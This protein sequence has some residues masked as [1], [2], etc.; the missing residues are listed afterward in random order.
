MSTAI[1]KQ[2][3]AL[4]KALDSIKKLQPV[5]W[6]TLSRGLHELLDPEL[7][8]VIRCPP[9]LLPTAQGR[10]QISDE[11]LQLLDKCSE[12]GDELR[13]QEA[14]QQKPAAGNAQ[15]ASSA[16]PIFS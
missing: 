6:E 11:V 8:H 3:I 2:Q 16:A 14:K 1:H 5:H 7:R 12:L 4:I 13:I 9:A 10:A 15:S